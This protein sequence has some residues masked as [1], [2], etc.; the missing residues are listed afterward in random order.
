MGVNIVSARH[1]API[2]SQAKGEQVSDR[3]VKRLVL[4]K[5]LESVS[6]GKVPDHRPA[7]P[8]NDALPGA[9]RK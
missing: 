2:N 4:P 9:T 8:G 5:G 3:A 6:P 7:V 1:Q